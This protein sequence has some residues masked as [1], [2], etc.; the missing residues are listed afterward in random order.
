MTYKLTDLDH[1]P[2]GWECTAC[3]IVRP[4]GNGWHWYGSWADRDNGYV[5]AML[6]LGCD[7]RARA[8][9]MVR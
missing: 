2:K 5:E 3:G 9:G 7:A 4:K 1:G 6:C 8:S